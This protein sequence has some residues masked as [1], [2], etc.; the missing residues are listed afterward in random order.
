[1]DVR[2]DE[3]RCE[4]QSARLDDPVAVRMED[5]SDLGDHPV[6]DPHVEDVVDPRC[7]V[8]H[9]CALE[10]EAF[11]GCLFGKEHH[12]TSVRE[13]ACTPTGP[14]VSRS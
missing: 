3:R 14:C 1:M 8:E 10:D 12:A 13:A 4:Q 7:R 6:V 2:I 5:G 9:A 11:L